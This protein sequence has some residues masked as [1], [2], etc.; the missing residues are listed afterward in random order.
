MYHFASKVMK[1]ARELALYLIEYFERIER[2][3]RNAN[4][5]HKGLT[6]AQEWLRLIDADDVSSAEL[7]EFI[8]TVHANWE[9]SSGWWDLAAGAYQWVLTKGASVAPP[10]VF[11]AIEEVPFSAERENGTR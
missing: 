4:V 3:Y 9:R 1:D 8:G 11:F 7:S 10:D 2:E 5:W 6:T